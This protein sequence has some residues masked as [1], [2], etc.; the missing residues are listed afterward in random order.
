MSN[1]SFQESVEPMSRE[2]LRV[3]R[4]PFQC[5]RPLEGPLATGADG[6]A[7]VRAGWLQCAQAAL[8]QLRKRKG[9]NTPKK[10]MKAI[11]F[12]QFTLNLG[13]FFP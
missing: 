12:P 5:F 11:S 7:W 6:F 13:H 4:S 1:I 10:Q 3:G 9:T 2:T 8:E